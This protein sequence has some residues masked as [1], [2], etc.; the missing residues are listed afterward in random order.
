MK[1][2]EINKKIAAIKKEYGEAKLEHIA[3]NPLEQFISW[4]QDAIATEAHD[5]NAM[6]LATVDEKGFPD[7]RIVLL[8]AITEEGFIFYSN[9][10]S[11][12]AR[13]LTQHDMAAINFYWPHFTRQVRIRGQVKKLDRKQSEAY[14]AT[15]PRAAQLG[16]HA[17]AQSTILPDRHAVEKQ[18]RLLEAKFAD[19]SIPCPANWGGYQLTPC[20][21]EFFQGRKWRFNDRL[22]YTLENGQWKQ[23]WL[24][25]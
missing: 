19:Q 14:F 3:S 12:K 22:L 25:P 4:L 7:T 6:L 5:P 18:L 9:Y 16:A 21:Y 24:A 17:S 10:D 13:Q 8:K 11:K 15:R 2:D 1:L 23:H 20:E